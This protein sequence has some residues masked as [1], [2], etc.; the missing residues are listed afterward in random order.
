MFIKFIY[1]NKIKKNIDKILIRY[2]IREELKEDEEK[3]YY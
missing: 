3:E 1:I 2:K